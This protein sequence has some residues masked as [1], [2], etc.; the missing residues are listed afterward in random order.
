MTQI[1]DFK[2]SNHL[3]SNDGFNVKHSLGYLS[4]KDQCVI[5]FLCVLPVLHHPMLRIITTTWFNMV[6]IRLAP[7]GTEFRTP[8]SF[9][10]RKIV[11]LIQKYEQLF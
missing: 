11:P 9:S 5:S 4:L 2:D 3:S 6:F 8:L 7:A 10:T 1:R